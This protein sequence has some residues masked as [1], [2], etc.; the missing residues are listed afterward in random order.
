MTMTRLMETV[1][2][3]MQDEKLILGSKRAEARHDRVEDLGAELPA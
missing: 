2:E 1:A 3:R